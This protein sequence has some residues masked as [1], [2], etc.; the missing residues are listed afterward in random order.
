MSQLP[1]AVHVGSE[2]P[3]MWDEIEARQRAA[4]DDAAAWL[5]DK[6]R[7]TIAR[8]DFD[9]TSTRLEP[10]WVG[11]DTADCVAALQPSIYYN[12]GADYF[13]RFREGA[14]SRGELAIVISPIGSTGGT[15]Y[16][17]SL[18]SSHDDS[19]SLGRV[20]SRISSCPLGLGAK[21]RASAGLDDIG[22]L[23]AL[24]MLSLKPAPKWRALELEGQ[25]R[26]QHDRRGLLRR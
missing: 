10:R 8:S 4:G 15:D 26:E 3:S 18:F 1:I 24:R 14:A 16:A 21:V 7:P 11:F 22:H 19:L 12:R 23:L 9:W 5:R 2:P 20:E 6:R 17:R 25:T 13:D